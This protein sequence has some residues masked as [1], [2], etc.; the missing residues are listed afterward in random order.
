MQLL[1]ANSNWVGV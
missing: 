1:V